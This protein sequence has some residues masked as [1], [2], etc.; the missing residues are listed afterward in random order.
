MDGRHPV[1]EWRDA[2]R[3]PLARVM[4]VSIVACLATVEASAE[5]LDEALATAYAS[6]P[7]LAAQRARLRVTDE[8]VPQALS[9]WR[10]EVRAFGDAGYRR[11]DRDQSGFRNES[12]DLFNRRIGASVE[13][14]VFRGGRT[15]AATRGAENAVRAERSRL[16][17]VEQSVLLNATT[18]YVDVFRDQAV[19]DLNVRN[20]Q[21]LTRQLEATRDR[22]QVG[23]VTRTDVFQA[24]ARLARAVAERIGAEGNL[25]ASRATY[26]NVVGEAPGRLQPPPL[27]EPLPKDL[28]TAIET[29]IYNNPDV[30]SNE[31]FERAALDDVDQVRGELLPTVSLVGQADREWELATEDTRLDNLEA[32][33]TVDVPLYQSGAVYSRLRASKQRVSEERR[34]LD[35]S[36]RDAQESATQAWNDLQTAQA[37]LLSFRKQVEANQ[38]ALEGVEREAEVGARTVLDILDA[39]QELLDSQVSLVR[40]QRD[41]TVAAYDLYAAVGALTARQLAL[42]V[43]YYDPE[44]Y[45]NE[46]RDRWFGGSSPGGSGGDFPLPAG[47]D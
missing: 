42:N 5:T 35:Q 20:E 14:P 28:P 45:Y 29:A 12:N 25:E 27:P 38:I 37:A 2:M 9:G 41:Q 15:L 32:L 19:L 3:I 47:V 39:E 8:Q 24:E 26:R 17:A 36:R 40:S 21:R 46:V 1:Y 31:F 23:E 7:T 18:A 43:E 13:Q 22:F 10:P 4:V 33:V 44:K 16:T 34:L 11:L 6:N 30:I